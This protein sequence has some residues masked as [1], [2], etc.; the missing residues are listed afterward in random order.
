MA[1]NTGL[2]SSL[3]PAAQRPPTR[4]PQGG[5]EPA[6]NR[7]PDGRAKADFEESLEKGNDL[8]TWE[9]RLPAVRPETAHLGCGRPADATPL[10]Q[11]PE[12]EGRLDLFL[13][14]ASTAHEDPLV[15]GFGVTWFTMQGTG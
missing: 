5:Y 15:S 4:R 8:T 13:V 14:P 2:L 1:W 11:G 7:Q 3:P 9:V 12:P 6:Q 10:E